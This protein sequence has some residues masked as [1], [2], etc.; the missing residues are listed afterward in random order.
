MSQS[1][2]QSGSAQSEIW[3]LE[4][5]RRAAMLEANIPWFEANYAP[6]L[7]YTHSNGLRD[8]REDVLRKF[9][10]GDLR[11]Q[12]AEFVAPRFVISG[13]TAV[14]VGQQNLTVVRGG[15]ARELSSLYLTVWQ[16][17]GGRWRVL[18]MQATPMPATA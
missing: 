16:Q 14:V 8:T 6:E 4:Q 9:R 1:P 13:D 2:A 11:Y 18:A 3:Q 12:R 17:Q 15:V 5:A 10:T 7:I